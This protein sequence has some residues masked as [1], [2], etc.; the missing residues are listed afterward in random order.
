MA[1]RRRRRSKKWISWIVI[2]V[3]LIAAVVVC[4]L[5]WDNYFRNK[6]VD[7]GDVES[8]EIEEQD[9][10]EDTVDDQVE[11]EAGLSS[12]AVEKKKVEQYDGADPNEANDLSG[13][14]TYAGANGG[15]LMIRLNIDQYLTDGK[16][17]LT[18]TRGGATIYNSIA[19]VV[20]NVTSA[21]CD[22]FDIPVSELGGG[23]V[24]INVNISADGRKGVIRGEAS[25]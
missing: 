10:V 7:S 22:G 23:N 25:I 14:I 12:S 17:E 15:K 9:A 4:Y 19:S 13:V 16:C 5:V 11:N 18:L 21:T 24:T 1:T 2:L 3:L 8:V 20:G 6:E